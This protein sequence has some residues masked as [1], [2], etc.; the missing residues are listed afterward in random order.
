MTFLKDRV[1]RNGLNA[2]MRRENNSLTTPTPLFK[3][4]PLEL[5]SAH[6]G[7]NNSFLFTTTAHP[8]GVSIFLPA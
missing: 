5:D 8:V 7:F 3:L 6:C 2:L 4:T 1:N